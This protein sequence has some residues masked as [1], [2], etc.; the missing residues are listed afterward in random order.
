MSSYDNYSDNDDILNNT[1]IKDV[2]LTNVYN[3]FLKKIND[4]KIY[5]LDEE[6]LF[7]EFEDKV[8]NG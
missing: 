3:Y 4:T 5:N 1:S 6:S 8:I 2:K 7:V